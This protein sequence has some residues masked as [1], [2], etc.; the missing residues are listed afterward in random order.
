MRGEGAEVI[1]KGETWAEANDHALQLVR[2]AACLN[3]DFGLGFRVYFG[4]ARF[5]HAQVTPSDAFIHPFDHELLWAGHSTLIDEIIEAGVIPDAVVL[6]LISAF[7]RAC[8]RF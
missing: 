5:M 7:E 8:Q 4:C 1:Q 6:P 3:T 2:L